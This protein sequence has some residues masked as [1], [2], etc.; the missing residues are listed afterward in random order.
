MT[1]SIY[2]SQVLDNLKLLHTPLFGFQFLL[3]LPV[4]GITCLC[5]VIIYLSKGSEMECTGL[6]SY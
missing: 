5:A 3:L 2:R 4:L 6:I 1:N